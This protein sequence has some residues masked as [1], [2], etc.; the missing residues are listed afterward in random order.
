MAIRYR[1]RSDGKRMGDVEAHLLAALLAADGW[2]DAADIWNFATLT[3]SQAVPVLDRLYAADLIQVSRDGGNTPNSNRGDL[4]LP[5]AMFRLNEQGR[6]FAANEENLPIA[7]WPLGL[8][9]RLR[10]RK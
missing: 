1:R 7:R 8:D 2:F 9:L 3:M 4:H 6:R 10:K 5:E